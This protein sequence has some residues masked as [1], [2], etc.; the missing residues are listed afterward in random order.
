MLRTMKARHVHQLQ[1]QRSNAYPKL[2]IRLVTEDIV[3]KGTYGMLTIVFT[4][5]IQIGCFRPSTSTE[6]TANLT[7]TE[8]KIVKR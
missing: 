3:R 7:F 1:S 4:L 5:S 8:E 6:V 2:I